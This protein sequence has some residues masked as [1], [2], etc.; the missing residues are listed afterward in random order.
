MGRPPRQPRVNKPSPL[1]QVHLTRPQSQ[2]QPEMGLVRDPQ[3]WKRFSTAV[4]MAEEGGEQPGRMPAGSRTNSSTSTFTVKDGNN[5]WLQKQRKKKRRCRIMCA[6]I[7]LLILMLGA[8]AGVVV[9]YFTVMR[10]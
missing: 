2:A 5:D 1:Q 9:W 7:T 10:K 8:G 6:T 4:H 3:F